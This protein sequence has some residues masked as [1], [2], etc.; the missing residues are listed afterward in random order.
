MMRCGGR[1]RGPGWSR[2]PGWTGT[3]SQGRARRSHGSDDDGNG[4]VDDWRGWDFYGYDNAPTSDPA[5]AHG[6]NV[7]GVLGASAGN[8]QGIAGVAP[9][10]ALLP[11]RTSDNILHQGVRLAEAITYA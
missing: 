4:Y 3:E 5:N 11:L 7:A 1:D 6:T 10:A 8:G 9:G 2:S